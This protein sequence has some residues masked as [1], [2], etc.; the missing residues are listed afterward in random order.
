MLTTREGIVEQKIVVLSK[1]DFLVLHPE[2]HTMSLTVPQLNVSHGTTGGEKR[3][4]LKMNKSV[5]HHNASAALNPP[6]AQLEERVIGHVDLLT[7]LR[8]LGHNY[9]GEV[10]GYSIMTHQL[11]EG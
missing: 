6:T 4:W 3:K 8:C 10:Q 9:T 1:I 2:F 11:S 7:P 5:W